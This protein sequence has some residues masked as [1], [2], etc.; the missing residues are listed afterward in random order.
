MRPIPFL[1]ACSFL[2][3]PAAARA[4]EGTGSNAEQAISLPGN[5]GL[6]GFGEMVD[7]RT[8]GLFNLRG[9]TRYLLTVRDRDLEGGAADLSERTKR[10]ELYTYVGLSLFGFLDFAGRIPYLFESKEQNVLGQP[11]PSTAD[12]DDKGWGDVDLA[13]KVSLSVGWF[14][15]GPYVLV[16]LPSSEPS[17]DD[18]A[19]ADYGVS[20]TFTL[21]SQYLTFHGNL[22][23]IQRETGFTGLGYRLGFALVL[24]ATDDFLVRSYSYVDGQEYEGTAK[25]DID[26]TT[27]LQG[28]LFGTL[29]AEVGFAYRVVDAGF[30]DDELRR[31]L[32]GTNGPNLSRRFQDDGSF[33]F[34]FSVG[35]SF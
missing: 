15:V 35:T 7:A 24:F 32:R 1:V 29:T 20:G 31:S 33:A 3:L 4:D 21:F 11:D 14:T 2:L 30:V 13:A 23:G 6:I 22:Y 34:Y 12:D 25:S 19:G 27:G 8:P 10:H 28:I 16:K 17:V 9:G 5:H 18:L 26:A